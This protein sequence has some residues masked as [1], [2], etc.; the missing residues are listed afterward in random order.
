MEIFP[1]IE[2]FGYLAKKAR[3]TLLNK[4]ENMLK[5]CPYWLNRSP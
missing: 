2:G 5:V 4:L 3:A 1:S